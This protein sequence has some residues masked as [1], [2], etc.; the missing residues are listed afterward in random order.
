MKCRVY[1]EEDWKCPECGGM[2]IRD[3][4]VGDGHLYDNCGGLDGCGFK[5][6]KKKIDEPGEAQ[7]EEGT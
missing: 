4:D 2:L 5:R 6:K 3:I 1:N 7:N